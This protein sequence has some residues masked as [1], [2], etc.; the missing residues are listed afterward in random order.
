M[1]QAPPPYVPKPAFV[2]YLDGIPGLG[3][4]TR[5]GIYDKY[6]TIEKFRAQL[7]IY[8]QTV[9]KTFPGLNHFLEPIRGRDRR[10]EALKGAGFY[11]DS[12][13]DAEKL[14]A[15]HRDYVTSLMFDEVRVGG[16]TIRKSA[17]RA[18]MSALVSDDELREMLAASKVKP[19]V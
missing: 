8:T 18:V 12:M 2:R 4:E 11:A 5:S 15:F 19:E 10:I 14:L 9:G 6:R 13:T 16:K 17:Q 3:P 7:A 1:A